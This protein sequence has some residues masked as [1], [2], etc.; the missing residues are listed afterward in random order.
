MTP[1]APQDDAHNEVFMK[2]ISFF[3]ALTEKGCA[4][5]SA[6]EADL[7]STVEHVLDSATDA[8]GMLVDDLH[9][10]VHSRQHGKGR[11]CRARLVLRHDEFNQP[12]IEYISSYPYRHCFNKFLRCSDRRSTSEQHAHLLL[13]NLQDFDIP[14]LR[15]LLNNDADHCRY[16]EEHAKSLGIGPLAP[17]TFAASPY[18]QRQSCREYDPS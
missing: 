2:T 11:K 1:L 9:N 3:C 4:F 10:P 6:V 17:C 5:S 16:I 12:Y 15:A 18:E 8:T 7:D 13:C 14:Y